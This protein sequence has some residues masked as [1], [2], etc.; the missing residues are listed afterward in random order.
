MQPLVE[1]EA[2]LARDADGSVRAG[3]VAELDAARLG[4]RGRLARGGSPEEYRCWSAAER[5]RSAALVIMEKI[6]VEAPREHV[7]GP[8]VNLKGE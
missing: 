3:L 2:R 4:M 7:A 1:L 6:K 8:A 5:A